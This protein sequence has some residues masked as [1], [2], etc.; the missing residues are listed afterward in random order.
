MS[1]EKIYVERIF[2]VDRFGIYRAG[3][4]LTNLKKLQNT[5]DK[6]HGEKILMF[7]CVCMCVHA[8]CVRVCV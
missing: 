2:E 8:L 3:G 5:S 7:K 4:R 6:K 1:S